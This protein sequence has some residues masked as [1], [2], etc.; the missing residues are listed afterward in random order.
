MQQEA[1]AKLNRSKQIP[2]LEDDGFYLTECSAILKN[3]ADKIN[4]K[5]RSSLP[6]FRFDLLR[7]TR[8]TQRGALECFQFNAIS[9]FQYLPFK[10][11]DHRSDMISSYSHCRS[12]LVNHKDANPKRRG[13]IQ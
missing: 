12:R 8:S 7:Q 6:T 10:I 2:V 4:F 13:E 3:L 11:F 1:C 5:E 9:S